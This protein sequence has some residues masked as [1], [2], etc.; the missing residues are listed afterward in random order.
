MVFW[1]PLVPE[2]RETMDVLALKASC[3][4]IDRREGLNTVSLAES[5]ILFWFEQEYGYLLNIY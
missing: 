3:T 4:A 2:N 5:T 1:A